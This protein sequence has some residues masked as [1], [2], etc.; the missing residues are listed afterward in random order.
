MLSEIASVLTVP[1]GNLAYH[2]I[3]ATSLAYIF[4]VAQLHA[5][6]G[7][8]SRARRWITSSAGLL[9]LRLA[10]AALAGLA[11]VNRTEVQGILPVLDRYLAVAGM[12]LLVWPIAFPVPARQGDLG[13]ILALLLGLLGVAATLLTMPT[14][15]PWPPLQETWADT[16]WMASFILVGIVLG[17]LL[18]IRRPGEWE[19]GLAALI[20]F[21]LGAGAQLGSQFWLRLSGPFAGFVRLAELA[22]YPLLTLGA[23]RALSVSPRPEPSTRVAAQKHITGP[24]RVSPIG[25]L[26]GVLA[27]VAAS[28]MS[29]FARELVR[30]VAGA[31]RVEFCLLMTA[32]D[33]QGQFAIA[34]GYDLIRETPL[35]GSALDSHQAPILS[36]A[37]QQRRSFSLPARSQSPDARA[38]RA[39]LGLDFTGPAL[40]VPLV[41]QGEIL[42]GLL[43]LSPYARRDWSRDERATLEMVAP[44]LASRLAQI[45]Q[46]DR[47]MESTEFGQ[48]EVSELRSRVDQ[49]LRENQRLTRQLS[50]RGDRAAQDD[51]LAAL[52]SINEDAQNTIHSLEEE[53]AR[54]HGELAE[55]IRM[56]AQPAQEKETT[57]LS[58]EVEV[59]MAELNQARS[60]LA[61]SQAR[62]GSMA[63]LAQSPLGIDAR[64]VST[65][66]EEI[67]QPLESTLEYTSLL[68]GETVGPLVPQQRKYLERLRGGVERIGT[69]LNDLIQITALQSGAMSVAE[70]SVDVVH[71]VEEAVMRSG[72]ALRAKG[73]ALR[74]EIPEELPPVMGDADTIIQILHHLVDNAIGASPV[75]GEVL[76]EAKTQEAQ[77]ADEPGYVL[78][79]VTD[80]GAGIPPEEVGRVFQ[81]AAE[82]EG[83][84]IPG[85]GD[86]RL[87]L[88][89]VRTLSEG[90][91]GRVWVDSTR[92]AGSR[93]TLLV[94]QA[95]GFGS[96]GGPSD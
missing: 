41:D 37:L 61:V 36:T 57:R 74:M 93:F 27:L 26:E 30:V 15:G 54:L 80:T 69:L 21:S 50:R 89:T 23:V 31:L 94:Q 65:I 29:D 1:P 46:R 70:T 45:R 34:A 66:A 8:S 60:D 40:L 56:T 25:G 68:L 78:V 87:G 10:I 75:G 79:S 43:V 59:L 83:G 9:A 33:E 49:L 72:T 13:M 67:R 38:L 84:L 14:A 77:I 95:P 63:R 20:L 47:Q 22:A 18:A 44:S 91:G 6:S 82:A 81:R 76:L 42:G 64:S 17:A 92:G 28:T 58:R 52:M 3:L 12:I 48:Q 24:L 85:L 4:A 16:A 5:R 35:A 62:A 88:H 19:Y 11:W 71:C 53:I 39:A 96:G 86:S 2:L 73:Q 51:N 90:I 32:P 7:Q 55:P